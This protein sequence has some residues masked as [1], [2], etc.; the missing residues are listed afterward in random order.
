MDETG[1]QTE[2]VLI[3][4]SPIPAPV[5]QPTARGELDL[6]VVVGL[7]RRYRHA[8]FLDRSHIV[9]PLVDPFIRRLPIRRPGEIGRVDIGRDTVLKSMFLIGAHKMHLS[10]QTRAIS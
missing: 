9:I 1:H 5:D 8:A 3:P 10:R 2:R 4:T 6:I 7:K